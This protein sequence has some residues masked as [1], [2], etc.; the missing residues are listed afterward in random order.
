MKNKPLNQFFVCVLSVGF[1]LF[2][3]ILLPVFSNPASAFQFEKGELQGSLDTTVSYGLRWRVQDRDQDIIGLTNGGNA[4]SVNGDNGNLNFT[5]GIVSN[6]PKI[7]SDLELD[8][9][10]FGAFVRGSAFY[11]FQVEDGHMNKIEL[12]DGALDL[13]GSDIK[14][15]DAY[16]SGSFE[17]AEKPLEIR[18]GDQVVSWGEGTFF[19][20]GI[21]AINPI[22]V[23]AIRLPGAELREAL[24]PEGMVYAA[25]GVTDNLSFEG[26]YLYNWDNTDIDPPGSY[27]ATTDVAG[28]GGEKVMLAFGS[29][30]DEGTDL[31]PLGFDP[32][33]LAVKRG[34]SDNA[35]D[36]GQYGMAFRYFSEALND[37]EFGFYYLN[38]HSR[39]PILSARTGTEEGVAGS[40]TAAFL[41]TLAAVGGDVPTAAGLTVNN[42]SKTGY[43]FT[44]YPEDIQMFGISFNTGLG[45]SGIAL[46]GEI[47][48]RKDLPLQVDDVE[49]VLA[50]LSPIGF[51]PAYKDNQVGVY[52]ADEIIHGYIERDVGQVQMTATKVFGPT[53]GADIFLLL[54][55]VGVTYVDDMPDQSEIRLESA[56][57]YTSGNPSQAVLPATDPTKPFGGAHAGKAYEPASHFADATS[58]GYRLVSKLVYEDAIGPVGLAPR[59]VWQHDVSGNSPGPGGNFIE[60]R[61]AITAGLTGTYLSVWSVDVSYTNFFG[62]DRYN[63]INDRDFIQTNIK[64][65]F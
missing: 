36:D 37:T 44:E 27:F 25:M 46:Q 2:A 47:A 51:N 21:N 10:N 5:T 45:A 20:G 48:Y 9:K 50:Y 65:S 11:D 28:E 34:P 52:S 15:L 43:Y 3:A 31:G 55:E 60:N 7:T 40:T 4:F 24:V 23:G 42:Y 19:Q 16:I 22:D 17:I 26:L 6:V 64:Y 12:T 39:V 1:I 30:S 8:Y 56:G 35:D 38:Y 41:Q 54:G 49:L 57:T 53:F 62:A 32:D 14:L 33:F 61:R 58:W 59:V 18:V 29:I 63:L 13:V